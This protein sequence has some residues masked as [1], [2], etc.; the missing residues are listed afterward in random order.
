[1]WTDS[2]LQHEVEK[3]IGWQ[4]SAGLKQISVMVKAGA[5]DLA[6]HVDS[7]WEKCAAESAAW[8]VV[9]VHR[10]TNGIRVLVPFDKQRA[11]DDIAL[12]AMG[13]LEWNCLVPATVEVQVADGLVTLSGTV[14]RHEQQAE[15]E[16]ALSTLRAI[17]GIRNN[18]GIQP[19]SSLADVKAPIEAALRRSA[20]VDSGHI[21]VQMGHGAVSLRG[22]AARGVRRSDEPHGRA[23]RRESE[24]HDHRRRSGEHELPLTCFS[25]IFLRTTPP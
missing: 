3:A 20:L 5:V 23:R 16:R 4:L 8:C 12:A 15:A 11:D 7:Y 21:K 17:T 1:M 13:I 6:G 14:E 22:L 10:V 19:S 18:I 9:H 24:D 2:E 25:S